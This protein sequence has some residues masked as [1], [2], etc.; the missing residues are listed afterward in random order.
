MAC[1]LDVIIEH[2]TL[3]KHTDCKGRFIGPPQCLERGL[4][5]TGSRRT[6]PRLTRGG[7]ISG[8]T[9]QWLE[10]RC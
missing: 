6:P 9:P 5:T 7:V 10:G 2:I 4:A 8:P 3:R 1:F